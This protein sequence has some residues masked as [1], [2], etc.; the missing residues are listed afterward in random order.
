M[1]VVVASLVAGALFGPQAKPDEL[2]VRIARWAEVS[3]LSLEPMEVRFPS[4]ASRKLA[5]LPTGEDVLRLSCPSGV[6]SSA[7]L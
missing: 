1:V 5:P 2:K 3:Q 7:T 6:E 4:G